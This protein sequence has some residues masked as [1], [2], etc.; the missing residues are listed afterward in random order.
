MHDY[1]PMQSLEL[2][3][4]VSVWLID[5]FACIRYLA[6]DTSYPDKLL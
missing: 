2:G 6:F 5:V 3:L 1:R 4:K